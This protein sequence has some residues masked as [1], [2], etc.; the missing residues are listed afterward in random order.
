MFKLVLILKYLRR[1]LA[2]MFAG[3]AV[4]LCTMMVLIVISVMGGFLTKLT[5][6]VHALSG[7]VTVTAG[8][9]LTGFPHY[10]TLIEQLEQRPEVEAATPVIRSFG[11]INLAERTI[12]VEVHGIHPHELEPIVAYRP[13]LQW[14]TQDYLDYFDQLHGAR[15]FG[16]DSQ[17]DL[18][19]QRRREIAG[20]D[21]HERGMTLEPPADW[22]PDD[23]DD[24]TRIP[25]SVIGIEVN[26]HHFRDELGQYSIGSSAISASVALTVV[27]MTERGTLGAYE[28]VRQR[29]VV[30][31]E[32]KSGAYEVDSRRVYVP[33]GLLQRLLEMHARDE[34]AEFDPRTGEPL[35]ETV[36]RPGRATEVLVA[37]AEGFTLGQVHA[38]AR[39]AASE[40]MDLHPD[41][42][43]L[44]AVT[45]RQ[46]HA[47][48]LAAVQNEIGLVTFLFA[49][50]SLVAVVM[51]ATTFYMIVLEKTRDIGVLR[52]VGASR[53]SIANLF[54]GYG[55]AIGAVGALLGMV[56][57]VAI[58]THLNDIQWALASRLG[59]LLTW[60]GITVTAAILGAIVGALVGRRRDAGFEGGVGGLL[61]GLV[62]TILLAI[63]AFDALSVGPLVEFNA[64]YGWQMWNPQT[65]YFDRIPDEVNPVQATLIVLA[66]ILSSVIG[67]LIPALLAARLDPVE[68]LRYE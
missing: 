52:A 62:G 55:A 50:I 16:G 63:F 20:I 27:P 8:F 34:V 10:E 67:A 1:K 58:V 23:A 11:L 21:L 49:I 51:V 29:L 3:L 43:A 54:L 65:Y 31:N 40:V 35:G 44:E 61:T 32:F 46:Q 24:E 64:T 57:A 17:R 5:E 53:W 47:H 12:P 22:R 6:S 15:A 25:G 42:P 4:T 60:V 26:P 36:E 45:W 39:G 41:M 28:P 66:A 33:F 13:A 68:A 56:A 2:P 48:L 14:S 30:V 18:I 38:A 7:D 37:G 9:S 59:T 19:E